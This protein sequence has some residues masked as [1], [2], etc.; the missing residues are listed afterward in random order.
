[1]SFLPAG[2][3]QSTTSRVIAGPSSILPVSHQSAAE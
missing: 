3:M 2:M 1:L